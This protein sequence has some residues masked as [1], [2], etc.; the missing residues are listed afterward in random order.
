MFSLVYLEIKVNTMNEIN[1]NKPVLVT[2]ANGYVASWIVKDLLDKGFHVHAAVRN[3]ENKNKVGHLEKL[4]ENSP[5]EIRLFKS[6]LLQEGSYKEAMQGCEV[7]FHTASPFTLDVKDPQKQLVDPAVNGTKNVLNSANE[8]PSVKRVVLTSS[9][10]AIYTDAK[11][12]ADAPSGVLTE[13]VWNTKSSL[14]YQPYS[15]SKTMAEKKAWEMSENQ[16]QWDLVVMNPSFVMGPSLNPNYS[17]SESTNV[18]KMLGNGEMKMGAPKMGVGVIDVR[19]LATAHLKGA[20]SQKASG[21]HII[22][23]HNTDYLEMSKSLLPKYGAEFPIPKKP[24]PKWL[25]MMVGPMVNKVFSRQF[26]KNNVNIE[27]K[28]DNSKAVKELGMTF[29]PLKETMEDGFQNLIDAG[30]IKGK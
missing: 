28:A 18:F 16:S 3:P 2:G 15:Y 27:W 19:D 7:V 30:I 22:S 29:R 14:S 26:I 21:R 9:C 11:D 25:L 13:D 12:C 24:L 17:T 1:K 20:F 6:D 4:A 8:T 23:A 5:G 10:A